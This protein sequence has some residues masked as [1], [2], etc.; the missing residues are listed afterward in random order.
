MPANESASSASTPR[1]ELRFASIDA[2]MDEQPLRI[3]VAIKV[4]PE[5]GGDSS[6]VLLRSAADARV[7]LGAQVDAAGVVREWLEIWVQTV[8]G[9]P[10]SVAAQRHCLSNKLLDERW[11][12]AADLWRD[13]DTTAFLN[14]G[15]ETR[16]ARPSFIDPEHS[17]VWHPLDPVSGHPLRL[18]T[19]EGALQSAGLPDYAGSLHRYWSTDGLGADIAGSL[20]V[21]A[22]PGAPE[23][24]AVKPQ[25][26]VLPAAPRLLPL[27][28]EGGRLMV[29]RHAPFSFEEYVD[30]LAGKPWRGIVAG[31]SAARPGGAYEAIENW[32]SRLHAGEHH[33]LDGRGRVGRF[34]ET[35]HLRLQLVYNAVKLVQDAVSRRQLPLL[36]LS[37]ASFRIELSPAAPGMPL[38]WTARAVVAQPGQ[39]V[40]L[41][42]RT[43]SVRCFLPLEEPAASIFR[44]EE[45]NLPV[46]GSGTVLL[47][48]VVTEGEQHNIELTLTT[49]E[50]VRLAADEILWIKLPMPNGTVDLFARAD[51]AGGEGSFRT[52]PEKLDRALVRELHESEGQPFSAT[53]FETVPL[54]STPCD[55]H[56]LGVVA[57]R[58]L[59]VNGQN[60]LAVALGEVQ[61]F[62]QQLGSDVAGD[63]ELADRILS[64]I[65]ADSRWDASLGAHRLSHPA[66]T[67]E[68][69]F[70]MLPPEIWWETVATIARFF[71]G[72]GRDSYC[73]DLGD[74]SSVAID[75][76]FDRPLA[77]LGNLLIRSRS[78]LFS[79]WETNR[80][81]AAVIERFR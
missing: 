65:D 28:P 68:E 38:L 37:T 49:S 19:D 57:V 22:T 32:D 53:D 75:K 24:P 55:L 40:A 6:L 78:L 11:R 74:V 61:G 12:V 44:P 4:A 70:T 54:Q 69:A 15:W 31:A 62:L 21:P 81:I 7:Y 51:A 1:R 59:L 64:V 16:P 8:A 52:I 77:D 48:R 60:N 63:G 45:I 50:T 13:A 36:N 9:L 14:T 23:T 56:A 58:A 17:T 42:I 47:R 67:P 34:L 35:F 27:N 41:P 30:L 43:A 76:V 10:A 39:A 79:D 25:S 2:A 71:P 26:E 80:D 73:R 18:C 20:F 29:R 66:I 3:C 46:R 33:F 72:Q 5:A